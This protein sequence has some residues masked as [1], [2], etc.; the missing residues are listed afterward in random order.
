M[1]LYLCLV[2]KTTNQLNR[3]EAGAKI[4]INILLTGQMLLC[5]FSEFFSFLPL[6]GW[7]LRSWG[8]CWL[9]VVQGNGCPWQDVAPTPA[10]QQ[11]RMS[12]VRQ[13][14]GTQQESG[15]VTSALKAGR[16]IS[17]SSRYIILFKSLLRTETKRFLPQ[18]MQWFTWLQLPLGLSQ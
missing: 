11:Q 18:R 3:C 16:K 12:P 6:R 10:H 1:Q 17:Q 14:L 8:A 9:R 13:N 7:F 5:L 15:D 2:K 4:T